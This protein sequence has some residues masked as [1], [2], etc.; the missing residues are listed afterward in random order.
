MV[1]PLKCAREAAVFQLVGHL[2]CPQ[3]GTHMLSK[4]ANLREH[5]MY[6]DRRVSAFCSH[7]SP[8]YPRNVRILQV[9]QLFIDIGKNLYPQN[10]SKTIFPSHTALLAPRFLGSI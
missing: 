2:D 7:H 6:P 10:Y 3:P 9:S 4:V 8:P 1:Q 5:A